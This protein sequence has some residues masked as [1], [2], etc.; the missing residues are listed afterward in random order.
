MEAFALGSQIN[1]SNYH[2]Y[3]DLGWKVWRLLFPMGMGSPNPLLIVN[4][5][6]IGAPATALRYSSSEMEVCSSIKES[7]RLRLFQRVLRT[8]DWVTC[9][10]PLRNSG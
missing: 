3:I 1:C 6:V 9:A 5:A 4:L 10:W 2:R 8:I 7:T